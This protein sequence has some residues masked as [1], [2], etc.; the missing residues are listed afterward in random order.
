MKLEWPGAPR[1]MT[2]DLHIHIRL[3]YSAQLLQSHMIITSHTLYDLHMLNL[4]YL[5]NK[6]MH[7]LY[8]DEPS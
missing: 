2:T 6:G 5:V 1:A 8:V 4:G 3:L 7:R